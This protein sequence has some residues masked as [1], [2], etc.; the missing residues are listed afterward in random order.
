MPAEGAIYGSCQCEV[1]V[2]KG[3][4][5]LLLVSDRVTA[6]IECWNQRLHQ[7]RPRRASP[8]AASYGV[9]SE[10]AIFQQLR[11]KCARSYL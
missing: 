5:L 8:K 4:N 7:L 2:A 11:F 6:G 1:T 3:L 10:I 9:V